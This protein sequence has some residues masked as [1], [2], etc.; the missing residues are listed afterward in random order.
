MFSLIAKT[1]KRHFPLAY[2][3]IISAIA[4]LGPL[5]EAISTISQND[6][7]IS[8][9][10]DPITRNRSVACLVRTLRAAMRLACL[11]S[12]SDLLKLAN[13][14]E[15][16]LPEPENIATLLLLL[17]SDPASS[18]DMRRD[19]SLA[20]EDFIANIASSSD[21]RARMKVDYAIMTFG[22]L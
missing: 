18:A 11:S 4:R 8:T 7:I 10:H 12:I 17:Y 13:R 5:T 15:L 14:S 6:V 1:N 2:S 21:G 20:F 16:S 9:P 22:F 3:H 19:I